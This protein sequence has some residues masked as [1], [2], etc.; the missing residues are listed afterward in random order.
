MKNI[1]DKQRL[2]EFMATKTTLQKI[3]KGILHTEKKDK[4]N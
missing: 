3:V 2:K 4:D 1:H